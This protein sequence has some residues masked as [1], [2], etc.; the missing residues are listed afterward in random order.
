MLKT[1]ERTGDVDGHV[2]LPGNGLHLRREGI[3]RDGQ[4]VALQHVF[5]VGVVKGVVQGADVKLTLNLFNSQ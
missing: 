1:S 2:G 5:D 3:V 4:V